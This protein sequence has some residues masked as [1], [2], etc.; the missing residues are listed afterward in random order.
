MKKR[1]WESTYPSVLSAI[2]TLS[3]L[4]F[5]VRFPAWQRP[6]VDGMKILFPAALNVSAI[7][8]GFLAT[9]QSLLLTL[10]D[11]PSMSALRSSEHYDRLLVFFSRAIGASFSVAVASALLSTVHLEKSGWL[12]I[13]V[14]AFWVYFSLCAV[15]CYVR[16]SRI[17]ALILR[18]R[19][20]SNLAL[21][22]VGTAIGLQEDEEA[23]DIEVLAPEDE[24]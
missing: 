7:A 12:R 4:I 23:P 1:D 22:G 11:S 15:L 24:T 16:T 17:M 2:V 6:L 10:N 18:M 19:P 21:A 8:V 9:S 5:F 20:G 13:A 14:A 3:G